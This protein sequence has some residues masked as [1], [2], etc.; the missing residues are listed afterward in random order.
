M[1]VDEGLFTQYSSVKPLL[2]DGANL[3]SPE[4]D[5]DRIGAYQKYE[6]I[7]WSHDAAF[8]LLDD[9]ERPVYVPNP[10]VIVDTTAH[11]YLKGLAI[12]SSGNTG[13]RLDEFLARE[14]FIPKFHT[15]KHSGVVRGDYLLHLTADPA[16]PEGTRLSINSV[17]PAAYFPEFDDDNLDRIVAVNLVEQVV[18]AEDPNKIYIK[19]LRYRYALQSGVR[20][21]T[22]QEA[23]YEVRDWWKG[24]RVLVKALL[25]EKV[26]LGIATIP[27]YHFKNI[28]WQGQPFGSSEL[29]GY[30]AVQQRINQSATDEDVS[31]ALEGL[32]VYATDAPPPTDTDGNEVPWSIVP[33]R[34]VEV[35]TGSVFK[36]VEGLK[37]V[38]PFQEHLHYLTE[39][40]YEASATFRGGS[41]DATVAES[42]IA[43]AIKFLPTTA[44]ME[45]RDEFGVAKLDQL[46]FDWK[47]WHAQFEGET[48]DGEILITL[49][50]KL[51]E[52]KSA[53]LAV[54]TTLLSYKL[55][56]KK[57][58]RTEVSELYALEIPANM[59]AEIEAELTAAAELQQKI[60]P[61][62]EA[63]G[64]GQPKPNEST[65]QEDSRK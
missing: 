40:M 47:M 36:R 9:S 19:R 49:S 26:L 43:L 46:F 29:R 51:P 24:T 18:D 55:V 27:V 22:S 31:L 12:T 1:A 32:G 17:D 11:F 58:A 4:M 7:Y 20:V 16:K 23:L 38:E 33:G 39:A 41:I 65:Q 62:P 50:D 8:K 63:G 59:E 21:V 45:Q 14:E 60:N 28:A 30:E 10:R 42:G 34:V 57:W 52:N 64:P 44:K 53:K 3:W 6:E 56:S 37:T 61:Q 48:L 35:P 15:S 5:R 25:P 2:D 54:I 13:K